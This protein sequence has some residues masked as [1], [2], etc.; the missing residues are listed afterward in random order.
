MNACVLFIPYVHVFR[1][2]FIQI[3]IYFR[4]KKAA[5]PKDDDDDESD[6]SYWNSDED[7]ESRYTIWIAVIIIVL[8]WKTGRDT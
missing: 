7:D 4:F 5:A 3:L 2:S 6:D 1:V 8:C